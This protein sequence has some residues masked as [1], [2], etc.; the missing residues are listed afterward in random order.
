MNIRSLVSTIFVFALLSS[1]LTVAQEPEQDESA[2]SLRSLQIDD[3][4]KIKSVR[5]PSLSSDGKLLAY[6]VTTRS[7]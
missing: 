1:A 4:F 7:Y 5:S 3:T 2:A 6:T